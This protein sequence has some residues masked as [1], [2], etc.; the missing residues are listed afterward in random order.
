MPAISRREF[1]K[2]SA[3]SAA[4]DG[5][6]SVG[7]LELN[8]NPLA[9]PILCQTWPDWELIRQYFPATLPLRCGTGVGRPAGVSAEWVRCSVQTMPGRVR[10]GS[11]RRATGNEEPKSCA[12]LR[13]APLPRAVRTRHSETRAAPRGFSRTPPSKSG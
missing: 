3:T 1:L 6:F 7:A 13:K 8:A 4:A 5:L 10:A 11:V 12:A 9:R 2:Y